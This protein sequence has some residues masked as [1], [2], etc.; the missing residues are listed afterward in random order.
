MMVCYGYGAG[1]DAVSDVGYGHRPS[2]AMVHMVHCSK[3]KSTTYKD[4]YFRS[5]SVPPSII[6]ASSSDRHFSFSQ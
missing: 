5:V 6:S 4:R 1:N 3:S 2:S